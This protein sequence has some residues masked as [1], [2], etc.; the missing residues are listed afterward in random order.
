[1]HCSSVS[2]LG[3]LLDVLL[4]DLLLHNLSLLLLPVVERTGFILLENGGQDTFEVN[5][6]ALKL[7]EERIDEFLVLLS[8]GLKL[9][10]ATATNKS[11]GELLKGQT[12]CG[13]WL[14]LDV[15]LINVVVAE[16]HLGLSD[17]ESLDT[18]LFA[19][20]AAGCLVGG[21]GGGKLKPDD[22]VAVNIY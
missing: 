4:G 17:L 20:T 8:T 14:E 9:D 3:H 13:V 6:V 11:T 16:E 2:S 15:E 21:W 7:G 22:L 1:M 5:A 19:N 10:K 18:G 12:S